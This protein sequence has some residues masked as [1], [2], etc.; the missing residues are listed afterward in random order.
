VSAAAAVLE[1]T[2]IEKAF[3]AVVALRDGRLTLGPRTI[4]GLVGPNG[5]GKSTLVKVATGQVRPDAGHI[6]I[7][8]TPANFRWPGDALRRGVAAMPQEL[9]LLSEL[10]VAENVVLGAEPAN[11][12]FLSP[13]RRRRAAKAVLSR[14]GLH[15]DPRT[16]AGSLRPSEQRLVMF[17][18]AL[19]RDVRAHILDEPTAALSPDDADIVLR[20]TEQLRDE[21]V[22]IVY[23]S[24]RFDEVLRLCDVV[25]VVRDGKTVDT[26][27]RSR[28]T[29]E[30]LVSAVVGAGGLL[31]ADPQPPMTQRAVVQALKLDGRELRGVNIEVHEGEIVGVVGLVGSGASELMQILGGVIRPRSGEV[32]VAGESVSLNSPADALAIGIA[33]LPGERSLVGFPELSVRENVTLASLSKIAQSGFISRRRE[34]RAISSAL[35]AVGLAGRTDA[36]LAALSGGNRQRALIAR[37]LVADS[38]VIVLEDPSAGVDAAA[39]ANLHHLLG[40]LAAEGRALVVS[41]SEPEELAAIAHRVVAIAHGRVVEVLEGERLTPSAVVAAATRGIN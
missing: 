18:H 21:G 41:S 24:H 34:K 32:R 37:A 29:R 13:R 22:S 6:V 1:L 10:S 5:A 4:H 20:V 33:F 14:V 38:R 26:V 15:V 31:E 7:D 30:L 8:R 11:G 9:A 19:L 35:E 17:A 36:K 39:R 2:G 16:T 23:V 3:G 27:D 28:L 40:R 12:F 25:S